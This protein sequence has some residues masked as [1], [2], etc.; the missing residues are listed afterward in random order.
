MPEYVFHSDYF[1]IRLSRVEKLAAL[2]F[3]QKIAWSSIR[4]ATQDPGAIPSQLGFRAPGTG[5][6]NMI[7]AGTFF[8]NSERQFAF[9]GKGEVPVVVELRNHKFQ[10]LILGSKTPS[11]LVDKINSRAKA[12]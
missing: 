9:W 3:N 11:E 5:F 4:G 12:A 6:P 8:K 2:R 7:A 1:E 10:R